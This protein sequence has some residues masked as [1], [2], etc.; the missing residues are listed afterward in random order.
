MRCINCGTENPD[1]MRFCNECGFPIEDTSAHAGVALSQPPAPTTASSGYAQQAARDQWPVPGSSQY[2]SQVRHQTESQNAY[3]SSA[4]VVYCTGCGATNPADHGL[5][6]KCG[7]PLST[8]P[9]QIPQGAASYASSTLDAPMWAKGLGT[10]WILLMLGSGLMLIIDG[11]AYGT[12]GG[13]ILGLTGIVIFGT[14]FLVT[15]GAY[16]LVGR[17]PRSTR[18]AIRKAMKNVRFDQNYTQS[19][20]QNSPYGP[21]QMVTGP[22]SCSACGHTLEQGTVFCTNCGNPNGQM[23][24]LR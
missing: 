10:I 24:T 6:E 2:E 13:G 7:A 11:I 15:F 3:G 18:K 1:E 8:S 19:T 21:Q 9:Q 12:T 23:Q 17:L 4:A 14:I 16:K 20:V 5:C 22:L